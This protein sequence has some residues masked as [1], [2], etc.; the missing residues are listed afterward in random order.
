[1]KYRSSGLCAVKNTSPTICDQLKEAC[2]IA[3]TLPYP[4]SGHYYLGRGH[5]CE[6]IDW[7]LVEGELPA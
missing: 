5:R 2:L 1:M 6:P 7:A 3:S 4:P